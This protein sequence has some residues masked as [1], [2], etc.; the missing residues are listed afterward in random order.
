MKQNIEFIFQAASYLL[1]EP[2]LKAFCILL[3][4]MIFDPK[5][6]KIVGFRSTEAHSYVT[7]ITAPMTQTMVATIDENF[8]NC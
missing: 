1:T 5:I 7:L 2:L 3:K 6:I 4:R 8:Y